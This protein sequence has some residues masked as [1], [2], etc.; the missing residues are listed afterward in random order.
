MIVS[1]AFELVAV[2][3]ADLHFV[4]PRPEP[5]QEGPELGVRVELRRLER[6]ERQG[7][8]Y[9]AGPVGLG[10]PLWR[11]DLLESVDRPG[12]LDRAHHHPRFEGWEPGP[13]RFVAELA[14]DPLGWLA[15]RLADL[16]GVARQAG[17]SGGE[18][19]PADVAAVAR[20]APQI[21]AAVAG[22]LDAARASAVG[23]RLPR[24]SGASVRLGGL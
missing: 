18:V 20:A 6:G 10:R 13:R 3:V 11:V 7:S 1:F 2:A 4:N 21:M 17:A 22:L 15:T 14:A 23:A 12:T 19:P 24:T 5:G 16:D 9:A 8:I